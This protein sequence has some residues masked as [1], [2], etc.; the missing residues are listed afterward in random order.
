MADLFFCLISGCFL[1]EASREVRHSVYFLR[2][3]R[4]GLATESS[5]SD[6]TDNRGRCMAAVIRLITE[7]GVWQQ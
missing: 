1:H 6:K 3:G 2:T 4:M 7:V 5:S